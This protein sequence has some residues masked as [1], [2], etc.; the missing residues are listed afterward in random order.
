[1]RIGIDFDNTLV[2]YDHVFRDAAKRQGLVDQAF[3]RVKARV[4]RQHSTVG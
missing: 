3:R 1:M 2:D 4:A